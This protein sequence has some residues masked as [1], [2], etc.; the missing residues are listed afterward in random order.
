MQ[1][2]KSKFKNDFYQRLIEFSLSVISICG[3]IRKNR[4]LWPIADQLIR[5]ATSV[6]ANVIEAKASSSKK[7][8][9]KF[10]EIALK[11][12]NETIYW[13]IIVKESC[14]TLKKESDVLL[15]EVEEITKILGSSVLT[16][17]GK[18]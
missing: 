7:E 18:K 14:P 1:N 17:K 2:D 9:I 12:A 10:F 16:L 4:N 13:L 5:S 3:H 11:S 15:K 8:Y 6:G